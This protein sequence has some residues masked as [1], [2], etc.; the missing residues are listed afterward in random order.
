MLPAITQA[1]E[2]RLASLKA[3]L[4]YTCAQPSEGIWYIAKD[5]DGWT[6]FTF[7]FRKDSEVEDHSAFWE[8]ILA[9]YLAI[10]YNL[11]KN[12]EKELALHSYG[13]PRGR[14]TRIGKRHI[15]YHG[16]DW[17]PFPPK[18]KVAT[19]FNLP[20]RIQWKYDEHETRLASDISVTYDILNIA[21]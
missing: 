2:N 8:H 21:I 15:V 13:F 19:V 5:T 18:A 17:A 10:K 12:M 7:P 20:G 9:P 14:V 6:L 16:N 1:N 4:Q 11:S 3:S